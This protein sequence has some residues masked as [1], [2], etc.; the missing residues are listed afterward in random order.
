MTELRIEAASTVPWSDVEHAM[1]GGGDGASCM[2]Q[3]YRFSNAEFRT[4][5]Q[6]VKEV[7]FA[8]EMDSSVT[9]GFVAYV[10]DEAAGWCRV[11]SRPYL[12]RLAHTNTVTK[13]SA[14][15]MDDASVWVVTCFVVRREFRRMGVS[16]AL[17][18]AAVDFASGQ[19]ARVIEAYPV[20]L[21]ERPRSSVNQMFTG[22]TDLY[23]AAGF[24]VTSR[25]SVGRAVMTLTV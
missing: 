24:Q 6:P 19:G 20:D 17:L 16:K 10:D 21:A 25:P 3:W 12:P 4:L 5:S 1:T 13:G 23:R 18:T 2:C 7:A 15:P 8:A 9:P 11:S 14:E 22:T